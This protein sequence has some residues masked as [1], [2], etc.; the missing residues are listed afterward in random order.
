[1][2]KFL[3]TALFA[4]Q[5]LVVAAGGNE[6]RKVST[7]NTKIYQQPGSSAT[8]IAT[9]NPSDEIKVVRAF[10]RKWSIVEVNGQVGYIQT[11]KLGPVRKNKN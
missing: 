10:D 3:F 8:V 1:M 11:Y 5:V 4:A 7:D 6:P 2:K 9:V